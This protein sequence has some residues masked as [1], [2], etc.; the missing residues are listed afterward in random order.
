MNQPDRSLLRNKVLGLGEKSIK[1]NYY[2]ELQNR[3]EEL[4]RFR[5][6]LDQI[7][8]IILICRMPEGLVIDLNRTAKELITHISENVSN[9]TVSELL[10]DSF[11]SE[12]N[13]LF[14]EEHQN[15]G[16]Q[17]N[18]IEL[19]F[20][21]KD[22]DVSIKFMK[23]DIHWFSTIFLHDISERKQIETTLQENRT[24]LQTILDLV[25]DA[26]FIQ[27]GE[28]FQ[29]LDVNS[30]VYDLFGYNREESFE[31]K[32]SD[33]S[34][35][36]DAYSFKQAF[37]YLQKAKESSPLTFEWK[38]R[39]KNGKTF[40]V[41]ITLRFAE[42]GNRKIFITIIHNINERKQNEENRLKME[43]QFLHT[44]KLE[45]LGVLAG[46]I[47]HDF[48]NILTAI[49]GHTE[50]SL[51][52]INNPEALKIHLN[53]I[54]NAS[55]RASELSQ[56]MLAYSGKGQFLLEPVDL[57][58]MIKEMLELLR[59]SISKKIS[60]NLNLEPN[61]IRFE[62]GVSQIR[63]ILMNLITNASEAITDKEGVINIRTGNVF[64]YDIDKNN[65]FPDQEMPKGQCVFF[66]VSDN[67]CGM[68]NETI[69]KMFDPFFTTKFTGRGLGMSAVLGIVRGHKGIINVYSE[70]NKG[71]TFRVYFPAK[72]ELVTSI[73]SSN[74]FSDN[75]ANIFSGK[76]LVVDDEP[77]ILRIASE[78][79]TYM[80]LEVDTATDGLEAVTIFEKHAHL[81]NLLI[82]DLT[83]PIISG[84]E[85]FYK[86][87]NIDHNASIILM[88]GFSEYE[89]RSRF[90]QKGFAGFI[91]KP[92]TFHDFKEKISQ[93][94]YEITIKS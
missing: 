1:K 58:I 15:E 69:N 89:L 62:G 71:T 46:G 27:D 22:F 59:V 77:E 66:E 3:A 42:I 91:Q 82:L 84:E 53:E 29:L 85:A 25:S 41:E 87:R 74:D 54:K 61:L 86:I 16:T 81:Y 40:W 21:R 80:G 32:I 23:Y 43:Q 9:I 94:F 10:G 64:L 5:A 93:V 39:H 92:F 88:S 76:V 56:Q 37:S 63:Q 14:L 75:N 67:G 31:K 48:N 4:E 36:E 44:Q 78:Y 57:N 11:M 45:S 51:I 68:S 13:R 20:N 2:S 83:M 28:S 18:N 26:I 50:L 90:A 12:M 49:M 55:K 30:S 19:S 7:E 17:I 52:K 47:A 73:E 70:V 38:A 72:N 35:L 34:A 33:F 65:Q 6:L 79:L 8:D 24:Y 60:L